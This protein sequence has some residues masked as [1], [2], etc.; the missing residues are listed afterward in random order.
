MIRHQIDITNIL[1]PDLK[2]RIGVHDLL[3]FIQNTNS[4][5]VVVD[6]ANVKFATRSFID[7]FY[8]VFI[9]PQNSDMLI[10]NVPADIQVI[11]DSV[12]QT[13]NKSKENHPEGSVIRCETTKDILRQLNSLAL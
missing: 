11:F 10:I 2:S 1:G 8:N 9:K 6:F 13:Q 5:K 7:E 12:K 3:L 4:E